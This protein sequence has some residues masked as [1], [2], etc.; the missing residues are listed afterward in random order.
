MNITIANASH[1]KYA[2]VICDT[3]AESARVRGTGIAK[4]TPEY[5]IKR[6]LNGNAVIALDG[7]RFAG[8]C[9]I[10]VWGH[11]KYVANSG[12]IVH[13]DYRNQ[14]LAKKIKKAI[15]DL[16]RKK[17]PDAKIF[18]ITTG[19]AVM[20]MNYELGYRP[21]TFSELTDDPEFWKGCQTCKN[22]DIL[23]RTERRM[24]L[25]TGM[26]YDPEDKS[27]EKEK[28]IDKKSFERLRSIKETLFLK[29]KNG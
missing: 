25:C 9:Y 1:V 8:F 23:T 16:S 18:G 5:I 4:R 22:F 15:F 17:F 11:Q 3:I 27:R 24:C 20:K 12:L 14:G 2:Q 6:L 10:E 29:K 13:P 26:L 21:V 7:D 28:K 19:L